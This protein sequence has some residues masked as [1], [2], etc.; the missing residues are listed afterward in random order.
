M[1]TVKVG[2][3]TYLVVGTANGT[4]R[5]YDD[6]F[7]AQAWFEDLMLSKIKSISFSNKEARSQQR[8][9]HSDPKGTFNKFKCPDFIVA[10]EEAMIMQLESGIFEAI[11]KDDK[12]GRLLMH[13]IQSTIIAV[14]VHP[15]KPILAIA[16][17]TGWVTFW[18]YEKR[19]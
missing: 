19:D 4:I 17:S 16:G 14:A 18:D 10:D 7:K 3:Q 12:K 1:M 6:Q 2:N 11:H 8:M 9:V 13:G 15:H 5:F